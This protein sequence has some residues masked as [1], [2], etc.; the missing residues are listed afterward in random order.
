MAVPM[1]SLTDRMEIALIFAARTNRAI[2]IV[3]LHRCRLKPLYKPEKPRF[4]T[5]FLAVLN[6][7]FCW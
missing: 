1:V 3:H 2:S 5:I 6:V 7:P 4:M